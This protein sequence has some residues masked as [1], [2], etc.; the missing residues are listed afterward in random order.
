MVPLFFAK[1]LKEKRGYFVAQRAQRKRGRYPD[2]LS[3]P[4]PN[5]RFLFFSAPSAR[6]LTHVEHIWLKRN[7]HSAKGKLAVFFGA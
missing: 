2:I 4:V 5:A 3:L 6:L 1:R 7:G